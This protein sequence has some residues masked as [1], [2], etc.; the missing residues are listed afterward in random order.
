MANGMTFYE[1]LGIADNVDDD[2]IIR[3]YRQLAKQWHPDKAHE[4]DREFCTRKFKQIV[5]AYEVLK[6]PELRRLYDRYLA[7][8]RTDITWQ[9]FLSVGGDIGVQ[10]RRS[11]TRRKHEHGTGLILTETQR[12][13]LD[14]LARLALIAVG[15]YAAYIY[16]I[17]RPRAYLEAIPEKIWRGYLETTL[18]L[19]YLVAWR[20]T[21]FTPP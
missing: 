2:T 6:D 18:P 20:L 7:L 11:K 14:R 16:F 21:E 13:D 5:E 3:V 12:E 10:E 9:E 1:A 19:S 17:Q 4:D 8:R 15:A